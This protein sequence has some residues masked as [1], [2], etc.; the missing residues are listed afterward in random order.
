MRNKRLTLLVRAK[1][2]VLAG[3]RNY[4]DTRAEPSF[5]S[6]LE[7]LNHAIARTQTGNG[8]GAVSAMENAMTH[9]LVARKQLGFTAP[10]PAVAR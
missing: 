7:W 4:G 9:M 3:I 10:R 6:A 5:R 1:S 2:S 8:D